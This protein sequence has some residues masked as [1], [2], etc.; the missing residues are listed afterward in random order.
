MKIKT[1]YNIGDI[2]QFCSDRNELKVG[3]IVSLDIFIYDEQEVSYEV[4]LFAGDLNF[5]NGINL[6]E[7]KIIKKLNRKAF[8]KTYAEQC[9]KEIIRK[10][11][12]DGRN[13][14]I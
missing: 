10:G 1:K 13:N 12:K 4:Q 11:V 3:K 9:A 14:T 6:K 8:E 5:D 7:D 2:I